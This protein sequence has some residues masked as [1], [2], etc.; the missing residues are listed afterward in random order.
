M[1][2]CFLKLIL[3][4]SVSSAWSFIFKGVFRHISDVVCAGVKILLSVMWYY[5][6]SFLELIIKLTQFLE[7]ERI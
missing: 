1:A 5:R 6:N 3:L 2:I 7:P 4:E